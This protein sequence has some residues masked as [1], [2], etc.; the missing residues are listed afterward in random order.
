MTS[1]LLAEHVLKHVPG[2]FLNCVKKPKRTAS[3]MWHAQTATREDLREER[4]RLHALHAA[5]VSMYANS[6]RSLLK[7]TWH[8]LMPSSVHSAGSASRNV[9]QAQYW[10]SISR[11]GSQ[12]LKKRLRP[13]QYEPDVKLKTKQCRSRWSPYH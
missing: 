4:A 5:S 7:I 13:K 9:R 8:I 10:S 2:I 1:A 12:R 3:C 11:R 6:V